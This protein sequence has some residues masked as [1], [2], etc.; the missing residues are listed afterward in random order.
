ML[1]SAILIALALLNDLPPYAVIL[2]LVRST[3]NVIEEATK[4]IDYVLGP[5]FGRVAVF[6]G[7][8]LFSALEDV[9]EDFGR[10][11]WRDGG[12]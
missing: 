6:P 11:G 7:I 3:I 2:R 1:D 9:I 5:P 12:G 10:G 4:G 8:D